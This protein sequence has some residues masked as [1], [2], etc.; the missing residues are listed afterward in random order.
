MSFSIL[1]L[2]TAHPSGTIDQREGLQIAE[3]LCQCSGE[4]A[5]WLTNIFQHSGIRQRHILMDRQV[6]RD[7]IDRTRHSQSMWLLQGEPGELGPT[8]RER[9]EQYRQWGGPLAVEA[10][11][12][13]LSQSGLH[14]RDI[15]HLVTVSC[16]GFF[17]PGLDYELMVGLDLDRGTERTHVGFMGCHGALNGL[18]VARAFADSDPAARVLICAV[19]LCSLHYYYR[20]D[21]Q[22][23]IANALFADGAAALV[24][25][26]CGPK[27]AWQA[28]A[29]GS[30]LFPDSAK[31]MTWTVGDHGFEMT[32]SNKVPGLIANHLP[33]WITAWLSQQGLALSDVASWC[34]H[35][36]GPKILDVVVEKLGLER[37][38]IEPSLEVLA[39][40]GNMSSATILFILQRLMKQQA[41]RPCVA[42][43][44]GPGLTAEAALFR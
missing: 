18:R 1:G 24:G 9:M 43:G 31:A 40:H 12:Q 13:A 17:A 28:A 6:V 21:P 38:V 33:A 22:K 39:D 37:G 32:L 41:P 19:E 2:G 5:T 35:P 16:T 27:G 44:F 29:S 26:A 36:G 11:R 34:I 3:V 10:A 20:W 25:S 7:V 15:T 30:W 23:V 4:Q 14:S 42:L 8:T